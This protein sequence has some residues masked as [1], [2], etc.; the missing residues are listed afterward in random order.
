MCYS[1]HHRSS[2]QPE[3]SNSHEKHLSELPLQ[4]PAVADRRTSDPGLSLASAKRMLTRSQASTP[5]VPNQSQ[6]SYPFLPRPSPIEPPARAY[7]TR[8]DYAPTSDSS[9]PFN[10]Y[11]P[12]MQPPPPKRPLQLMISIPP[13]TPHGRAMSYDGRRGSI[14]ARPPS[15]MPSPATPKSSSRSTS[16]VPS[17]QQPSLPPINESDDS[18]PK[19]SGRL[20][21]PSPFMYAS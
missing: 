5:P 10:P 3:V 11:L 16:R 19:S 6:P 9:E 15:Q 4:V 13:R 2:A 7:G 14:P 12:Y 1:D 17:M 8:I 20:S 18:S 21:K